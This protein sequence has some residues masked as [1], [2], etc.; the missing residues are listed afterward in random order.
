M[1][2]GTVGQWSDSNTFSLNTLTLV[3]FF[4]EELKRKVNVLLCAKASDHRCLLY[5]FV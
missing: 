1:H 2:E 4:G 5:V 3:S